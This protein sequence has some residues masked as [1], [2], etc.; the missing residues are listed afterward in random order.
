MTRANCPDCDGVGTLYA[1]E[2][3]AP[4]ACLYCNGTGQ[5]TVYQAPFSIP[6]YSAAP[7]AHVEHDPSNT[8]RPARIYVPGATINLNLAELSELIHA[9]QT[10][11]ESLKAGAL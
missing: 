6:V 5:A 8:E 7:V 4:L 3:N 1:G 2:D 10:L 11:R 9:C